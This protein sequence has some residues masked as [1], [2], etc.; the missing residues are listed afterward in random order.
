MPYKLIEGEVRLFYRSTKLVGSRPDGDSVW[1]KPD[2]P[3]LLS[4]IDGRS[5]EFNGGG[6]AQLRFEGI[7]ALE[8]HFPGSDHQL[9]QPTVAARNFLLENIQPSSDRPYP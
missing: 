1:F 9:K 8:L 6:F 3:K 2:N 5:A 7:D 4:D